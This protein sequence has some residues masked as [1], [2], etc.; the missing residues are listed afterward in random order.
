[1]GGTIKHSW[2]GT[3]L[4]IESD[5]GIS[6]ADL[7]GAKGDTGI[8]GAQ[9]AAGE[10]Y[11]TGWVYPTI[12]SNYVAYN[13]SDTPAYRKYGQVLH[14]SGA[15]K[16]ATDENTLNTTEPLVVFT[17]PKEFRPK[18]PTVFL[19]QDSGVAMFCLQI[20]PNGEVGLS[21]YREG[22]TNT[23]PAKTAWLPITATFIIK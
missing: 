9:G 14:I 19:Q 10:P 11:D 17:L 18:A 16:P 8:R 1:M 7:K 15:V 12:T 5:S 4:T 20:N 3:V 21:R 2:N 22:A 23:T 13:D 6:S